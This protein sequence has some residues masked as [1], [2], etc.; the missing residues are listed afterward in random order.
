MNLKNYLL[1]SL[2][3]N[4]AM[5]QDPE[6]IYK[7]F[8]KI[9]LTLDLL[10]KSDK[11]ADFFDGYRSNLGVVVP[12]FSVNIFKKYVNWCIIG[13]KHSADAED[14]FTNI[15][16]NPDQFKDV[17]EEDD[18]ASSDDFDVIDEVVTELVPM[19]YKKIVGKTIILW[20]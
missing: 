8:K 20:K 17:C 7:G 12:E 11:V 18:L 4:E 6:E 14:W 9:Q 15:V 16:N 5:R 2:V 1:E 13:Y 19:A 10:K 3:V